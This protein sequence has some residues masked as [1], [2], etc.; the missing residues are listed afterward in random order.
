MAAAKNDFA[1]TVQCVTKRV[2]DSKMKVLVAELTIHPGS[3]PEVRG[4][5]VRIPPRS[6]NCSPHAERFVRTAKSECIERMILFGEI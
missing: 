6:P 1:R 4:G 2:L 3:E 5:N